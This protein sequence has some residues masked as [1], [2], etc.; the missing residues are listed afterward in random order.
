MVIWSEISE[1]AAPK[2]SALQIEFSDCSMVT[3]E[4]WSVGELRARTTLG[5]LAP[6]AAMYFKFY[7]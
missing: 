5:Y 6:L 3:V 1:Q 7:Q 4:T 2:V